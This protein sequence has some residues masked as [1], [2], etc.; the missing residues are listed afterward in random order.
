MKHII[1]ILQFPVDEHKIVQNADFSTLDKMYKGRVAYY[2]DYHA[3]SNSGG[4]SDGKVTLEEWLDQMK[5]QHIDFIGVMDHR[6]V[7]HMYLEE[8]DPEY[9]MYGT[10]PA[11][12]YIEPY[13]RLHYLMIFEE[14]DTLEKVLEAYPDVFEFTGGVEGHFEYKA[15]ERHRFMEVVQTVRDLG[16]VFVHAHPRQVMK[17]DNIDDFYFGDGTALETIYTNAYDY[18]HNTDTINNYLLWIQFLDSGKKVYN[19]ATADCHKCV[20]NQGL[21]TVYSDEKNGAAYVRKLREGDLNAGFIGIKMCIDEHPVGSTAKY[22]DGMNLYVKVD[23]AH[24]LNYK[25]DEKYRLD[26][27][28]DEGIAYSAPLTIPFAAA[29]KVEKR[30][31]YRVEI[32]RESDGSPAAI[33]NPIWLD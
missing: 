31:F 4:T 14:R 26:I 22:K 21:N 1:P 7:R 12:E 24:P 2:G 5:E 30:R 13:L 25:P 29:I 28:T 10:E 17:S 6:Q 19:T 20:S 8:F 16:G 3:H 27:I 18:P 15:V 9:F 33:G 32:V 11:G 23:D